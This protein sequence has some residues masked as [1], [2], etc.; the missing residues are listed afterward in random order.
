MPRHRVKRRTMGK[1][2]RQMS[3]TLLQDNVV[4]EVT[5]YNL[6]EP[7]INCSIEGN[8]DVFENADT[9]KIVSPNSIIKYLNLRLETG[10]RDVAPRAPG[11]LEFAIVVFEEQTTTPSVASTITSGIGTKTLG[12]MTNN[13]YRGNCLWNDAFRVSK[14]L[15]EVLNLKIKL[16]DKWCKQK[17]GMYICLLKTYRSNDVSDTTTDCRSW[18]SHQ[19]KV[20]A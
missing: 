2:P 19:Y 12:T 4:D 16:P 5:I 6:V 8:A 7:T 3:R 9:E 18:V 17:R 1:E 15:P 14:E 10:L 11:F 13:L 20:Y